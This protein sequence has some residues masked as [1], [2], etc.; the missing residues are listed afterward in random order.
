MCITFYLVHN[1]TKKGRDLVGGGGGECTSAPANDKI[2]L[3]RDRG[4]CSLFGPEFQRKHLFEA[5]FFL[6]KTLGHGL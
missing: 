1:F 6:C 3:H 2:E 5:R 4:N